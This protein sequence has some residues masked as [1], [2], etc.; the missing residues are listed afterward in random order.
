MGLWCFIIKTAKMKLERLSGGPTRH[1]WK[2]GQLVRLVVH[3][4]LLPTPLF[5]HIICPHVTEES[6]SQALRSTR[7]AQEPVSTGNQNLI[8]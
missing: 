3:K 2:P 6:S 7:D 5:S 8:S 4:A 1:H